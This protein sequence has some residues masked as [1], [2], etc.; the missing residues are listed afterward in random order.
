MKHYVRPSMWLAFLLFAWGALTV[1]FAGVQ[2]Y[3]TVVALRFLIGVFEAGFFPGVFSP[4]P[5]FIT[6]TK[7]SHL[8][9]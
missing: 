3:A 8:V 9:A 6:R 2:N 5:A 4:V 7:P 1:G